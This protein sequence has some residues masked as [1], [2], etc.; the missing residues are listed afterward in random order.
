[1]II[2]KELAK[3]GV[4]EQT[5]GRNKRQVFRRVP[6][7]LDIPYLLDVQ[8]QSFKNFLI[9]GIRDVF[10]EFNPITDYSN[11]V[12]M[13][14][15]DHYVAEDSKYDEAECLRRGQMYVKPLKV[16]VRVV[17]K[18]TGEVIEQEVFLGDIPQM[19]KSGYF[20]INGVA[21]VIVNQ[22]I[23]SPNVYFT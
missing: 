15:L 18:E 21:R 12:E 23:K 1:M 8:T 16:K 22:I 19:T 7:V 4:Y 20:I 9:N 14:F 11:K 3:T 2:D 17:F 6:E 10:D 5:F 13:Y